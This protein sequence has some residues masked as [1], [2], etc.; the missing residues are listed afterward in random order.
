[1]DAFIIEFVQVMYAKEQLIN[2]VTDVLPDHAPDGITRV[3]E[4]TIPP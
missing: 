1:M 2:A 3:V 4:M